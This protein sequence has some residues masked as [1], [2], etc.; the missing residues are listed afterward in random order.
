MRKVNQSGGENSWF[1]QLTSV[2]GI[3]FL[4]LI[5]QACTYQ[6]P[7]LNTHYLPIKYTLNS[8]AK[9]LFTADSESGIVVILNDDEKLNGKIIQFWKSGAFRRILVNEHPYLKVS[10]SDIESVNAALNDLFLAFYW[11]GFKANDLKDQKYVNPIK[12]SENCQ[13]LTNHEIQ[14]MLNREV[15]S[16]FSSMSLD[17]LFVSV[18]ELLLQNGGVP[19]YPK[20]FS[21]FLRKRFQLPEINKIQKANLFAEK[22]EGNFQPQEEN[23][24][25]FCRKRQ[26][27]E[28]STQ[29]NLN[30]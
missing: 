27:S 25:V 7:K 5:V 1:N 18:H 15:E 9:K 21:P 13:P 4:F 11:S 23:G 10:R 26:L 19:Q 2:T 22:K 14:F 17:M 28:V 8:V 16:A 24:F 6:T 30:N 20:V 29:F 12:N 3:V